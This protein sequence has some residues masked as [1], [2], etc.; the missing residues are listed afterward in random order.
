MA[1]SP[2]IITPQPTD[3]PTAHR[4]IAQLSE[5][6][7]KQQREIQSL[8]DKIDALC[9]KLFGRSSEQV[10]EAQLKLAFAQLGQEPPAAAPVEA[11][12]AE[13]MDSG[14]RV[15]PGRP[16]RRPPGRQ[17]L[18]K[19]L[20]RRR[21]VN[22]LSEVDK[23][24]SCGATKDMIGEAV[25]EKLDYVPAS[26]CVV[27]T[28]TPKYACPCCHDGV[29][30]AAA[31]PQAVEKGLATEGLLAYV[32]TSKYADHLPLHRLERI[33]VRQGALISRSTMCGWVADVAE[34]LSPIGQRLREEIRGAPYLQ[35][36]D[37]PVTVLG[38]NGGSF[39]GRLWVYLDPLGRQ[40]VYD[41][42]PTHERVG[43][44][45]F[46][47]GFR[48][49]MQADAYTGYD[50]LY[51]SGRIVEVAC[52]AH[53]RRRF[54]EALETDPRAAI[55][56]ALVKQLYEVESQAADLEPDARRDLRQQISAP[57]LAELDRQRQALMVD[58]LPKS[59]LGDAL[60]YLDNQWQPLQ[61]FLEDGRLRIDNNGAEGQLR[62]VAVGRN[63]WLFAGSMAGAERTALLYS[64]VQSCRLA[65]IDPFPYFRDVL[66]RVATHPQSRVAEL[67]PK[68]WAAAQRTQ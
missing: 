31:R 8:R 23:V 4:V 46:L 15:H 34:A 61:R 49:Y 57:L 65:G 55:V 19:H 62:V 36:D 35:T 47:E 63:N 27:E 26:L 68:A 21:E 43:P 48:G 22:D 52:W 3:L 54:V 58:A 11:L 37:T 64:L 6:L 51:S 12:E 59:P 1:G 7:H 13:E 9:R 60:R 40:V 10:S 44:E 67:T 28:V 45:R 41:A 17:A 50:A 33:F 32:V 30:T 18:P 39:K 20:P 14:E 2:P 38:E 16:R 5:Q 24:C 42:T 25:A 66:I 53:A 56:V 29:S